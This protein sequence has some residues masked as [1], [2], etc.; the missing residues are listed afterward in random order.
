M[1]LLKSKILNNKSLRKLL[2]SH[3]KIFSTTTKSTH[4]TRGNFRTNLYKIT[5]PKS[6]A[7]TPNVVWVFHK[8]KKLAKLFLKS[9]QVASLLTLTAIFDLEVTTLPLQYYFRYRFA[10]I[11]NVFNASLATPFWI[12]QNTKVLPLVTGGVFSKNYLSLSQPYSSSTTQLKSLSDIPS[13][14]IYTTFYSLHPTGLSRKSLSISNYWFSA[15][16][17]KRRSFHLRQFIQGFFSSQQFRVELQRGARRASN[18][19]AV[20]RFYNTTS[21]TPR[22]WFLWVR[23]VRFNMQLQFPTN[24]N[25]VECVSNWP[26]LWTSTFTPLTLLDRSFHVGTSSS[27]LKSSSL[28][29]N[30]KKLL[31]SQSK[32]GYRRPLTGRS[33]NVVSNHFTPIASS[34]ITRLRRSQRTSCSFFGTPAAKLKTSVVRSL[35]A[36]KPTLVSFFNNK[37]RLPYLRS[38]KSWLLKKSH[39]MKLRKLRRRFK[40]FHNRDRNITRWDKGTFRSINVL[41][42]SNFT[43][44]CS[45]RPSPKI[46]S[47]RSAVTKNNKFRVFT[48]VMRPV[49]SWIRSS[50]LSSPK[51]IKKLAHKIYRLL[52]FKTNPL[53]NSRM[54]WLCSFRQKFPALIRRYS[55]IGLSLNCFVRFLGRA[56]WKHIVDSNLAESKKVNQL[57]RKISSLVR[58]YKFR[59]KKFQRTR[60]RSN[61]LLIKS[62]TI[63]FR[64]PQSKLGLPSRK[65][66]PKYR[67]LASKLSSTW[68]LSKFY[69]RFTRSITY[70]NIN[71][72][73][74]AFVHG[75]EP[76]GALYQNNPSRGYN[77]L[78][79]TRP[80]T[81][82][83][84]LGDLFFF[85]ISTSNP[86]LSKFF[87]YTNSR[88]RDSDVRKSSKNF[89]RR[90]SFSQK[91]LRGLFFNERSSTY[92]N[93]VPYSNLRIS[94]RKRVLY[95][96]IHR[97]FTVN[98]MY[99][100]YKMLIETMEHCTGRKIEI[101]INTDLEESLPFEDQAQCILWRPRILGFQ[102]MM[103]PRIFVFEALNLVCLSLRLK[104][105][106]FLANWIRGMLKRLSFWKHRLIFRYVRYLM[107]Y[108]FTTYFNELEFRG[109]KI[110]LKGKISV[111]GNA[112]TRTL[113]F[114]YG[115]TSQSQ[116]DHKVAYD[117]SFVETFTGIMGFKVWF[118][119]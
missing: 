85:T 115:Q 86:L 13:F 45:D 53:A 32:L 90:S 41:Q 97:I 27:L 39:S 36:T 100:K 109:I 20:P 81:F 26:L 4:L 59:K 12:S 18:N 17:N 35:V 87:I 119:Y 28:S 84:L 73:V 42:L 19:R 8:N 47:C 116:F 66:A 55:F 67:P 91:E 5:S 108:L 99:W 106:T 33:L 24:I 103:G 68:L 113:F 63:T 71:S 89:L 57:N 49:I 31:H 104:D 60:F 43:D 93:L 76:G 44:F 65:F 46:L 21:T 48:S 102:R 1:I 6:Y 61:R 16:T 3:S 9:T 25:R 30:L 79:K 29:V 23:D 98:V 10:L 52:F 80:N 15:F 72:G 112:R 62:N 96:L 118:F 56:S 14:K 40:R 111:A 38:N 50:V 54:G 78:I 69:S 94:L 34:L 75:T 107:R 2:S 7:T 95:R 82:H 83:L 105:P 110:Q 70:L 77:F 101:R 117:L 37:P 64:K 51:G 22:E 114:A 74:G 11:S 88:Y 58:F 92:S